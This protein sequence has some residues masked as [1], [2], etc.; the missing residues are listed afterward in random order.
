MCLW[1]DRKGT[2]QKESFWKVVKE[3]G[4]GLN[5][6]HLKSSS[7]HLLAENCPCAP[8]SWISTSLE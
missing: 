2:V 4:K 5:P 7:H 1:R 3:K 8:D 6:S